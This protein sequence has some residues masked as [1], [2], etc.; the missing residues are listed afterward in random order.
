MWIRTDSEARV[1]L[2]DELFVNAWLHL[3]TRRQTVDGGLK[4]FGVESEP[5]GNVASAI[6]FEIAR[7]KLAGTRRVLNL[8]LITRQHIVAGDVDLVTVDANV[9]V[10]DELTSRG[11]GLGK[12]E[13]INNT[14]ETGLEELEEAFAGDATFA[15]GVFE[16]ATELALKQTVDITQ[17]LLF[18]ETNRVLG[19]F[20]AELRAVLAWW[21]SALFVCLGGAENRLAK[22]AADSGGRSGVT[23]HGKTCMLKC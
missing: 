13:E 12:A 16:D 18:V 8:Y 15:F 11:A 5:A 4:G 7:G 22:T 21:I 2:D 10:I 19:E 14:I 20:A 1:K 17:L 6:L 23:S 9:T 3:V